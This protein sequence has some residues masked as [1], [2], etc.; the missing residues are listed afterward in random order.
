M[1]AIA[2]AFLTRIVL[3]SVVIASVGVSSAL[4]VDF[5]A[6]VFEIRND[7][8]LVDRIY[9]K[10]SVYKL[11]QHQARNTN[12]VLVDQ[13][14]GITTVAV[15]ESRQ[16]NYMPSNAGMS[17]MNDPFQAA[18]HTQR[19]FDRRLVGQET[20]NGYECDKYVYYA[21]TL[22]FAVE[23][24]SPKL[25]F[26]MRFQ[27]LRSGLNE[28]TVELRYVMEGELDP[29]IFTIPDGYVLY[30]GNMLRLPEWEARLA[31]ARVA[32]LPFY[33]DLAKGELLRVKVLP[34]KSIVVKGIPKE[35]GKPDAAA[36][37]FKDGKPSIDMNA[38]RMYGL[39]GDSW[40]PISETA[41]EADEIVV[42]ANQLGITAEV[43]TI[44]HHEENV[45]AGQEIRVPM[46]T[47]ARSFIRVVNTGS[48]PA[49]FHWVFYNNGQPMSD[50]QTDEAKYRQW[51]ISEPGDS[52][53][54]PIKA[55]GDELLFAVDEGE[56]VVKIGQWLDAN[57][58]K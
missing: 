8:T 11:I 9:V 41:E 35:E 53:D 3:S 30:E 1:K 34:G 32:E 7:T 18:L 56:G 21:D 15:E 28:K 16:Y 17:L 6:D 27:S 42:G 57:I 13:K 22:D 26:P 23:W 2:K 39:R 37:P 20:V 10:D 49:R 25:D 52:H 44:D 58:A 50:D 36:I 40:I 51:F 48:G 12:F 5:T 45:A 14:E 33:G 24:Y 31:E 55:F 47:E 29:S 54:R 4:A 46:D 19:Q 38:L 43:S